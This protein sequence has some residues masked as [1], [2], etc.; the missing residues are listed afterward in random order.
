VNLVLR[1]HCGVNLVLRG[2]CR[3]NLVLC[4]H[5]RVNLVSSCG[6]ETNLFHSYHSLL[7]PLKFDNISSSP[8]NDAQQPAVLNTG[9]SCKM[10]LK[11]KTFEFSAVLNF[12]T[13]YGPVWNICD[14]CFNSQTPEITWIYLNIQSVPLSKHT[15]VSA[16]KTNQLKL[17][18]EI[19]AV[20]SEIHTKHTNTPC[21][22]NVEC[23][24]V[25]PGGT[26]SNHWASKGSYET[27][28]YISF[29]L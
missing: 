22:L 8:C 6:S 29:S 20:C 7:F 17:Y 26:Y 24:N 5:C 27:V 9:T 25:K 21:G 19:I 28:G 1:G 10:T 12:L 11:L 15:L 13:I 14:I 2:H 3:V 16:I 23:W 4:R 18:R